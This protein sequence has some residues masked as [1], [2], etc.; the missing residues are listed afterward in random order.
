MTKKWDFNNI[1]KTA[2][3]GLI[4]SIV[5]AIIVIILELAVLIK[6]INGLSPFKW[7]KYWSTDKS[8]LAYSL[9]FV[10]AMFF[11]V[12]LFAGAVVQENT[13][14]L[15]SFIM[16]HIFILVWSV[17]IHYNIQNSMWEK[18]D[19]GLFSQVKSITIA[20]SIIIGV[21]LTVWSYICYKL[22]RLY[23]WEMY[24]LIGANYHIREMYKEYLL[25]VQ[26]LKLNY[27]TFAGFAIQYT[28][29]VLKSTDT[30]F[31]ITVALIPISL[32]V[33]VASYY[34]LK[35]ESAALMWAFIFGMNGC[36]GYYVF[37]I[38]RMY[39]SRQHSKYSGVR[40]I[41]TFFGI[42]SLILIVVTVFQAIICLTNFGQGLLKQMELIKGVPSDI[43]SNGPSF[44]I[45]SAGERR[46]ALEEYN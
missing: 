21:T 2:K 16:F 32:L 5:Q 44:Y 27:F 33:L 34:A 4:L 3:V 26:L 7:L 11:S 43:M 41:M 40:A 46:M 19:P 14:Q 17:F 35:R 8:P 23:G 37:K 29:L 39:D 42:I 31:Y 20:V 13:L 6:L 45:N 38:A 30:E 24:K 12:Y 36:I 9:L 28:V 22:Y 1:P 25:L 15:I 18:Y 10:V